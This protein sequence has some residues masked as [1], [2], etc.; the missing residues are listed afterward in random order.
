MK[1]YMDMTECSE[2]HARSVYIIMDALRQA[3]GGDGGG[4]ETVP[5]PLAPQRSEAGQ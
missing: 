4:G 5:Q 2:Q 1:E 3:E